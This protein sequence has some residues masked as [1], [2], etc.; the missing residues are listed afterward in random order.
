MAPRIPTL[1]S[2]LSAGIVAVTVWLYS[3][4]YMYELSQKVESGGW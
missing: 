2:F 3:V 1:I 4:W